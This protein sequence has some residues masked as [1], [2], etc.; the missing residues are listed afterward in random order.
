MIW[1]PGD[2]TC[3]DP[4]EWQRLLE[5]ADRH[6]RQLVYPD[7]DGQRGSPL[8]MGA[9]LLGTIAAAAGDHADLDYMVAA[10]RPDQ[11]EAVPRPAGPDRRMRRPAPGLPRQ[12]NRKE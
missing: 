2:Q 7:R 3:P 12:Q 4:S 5:A 11:I 1:M 6:Q 8:V 9:D 10:L